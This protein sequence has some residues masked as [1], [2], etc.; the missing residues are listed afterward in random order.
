[1]FI[2]QLDEWTGGR[3]ATVQT[4]SVLNVRSGGCGGSE[5]GCAQLW[6][7][8]RGSFGEPWVT[9]REDGEDWRF[10]FL[11]IGVAK[12]PGP[13]IASGS[14]PSKNDQLAKTHAEALAPLDGA[15][16]DA[17]NRLATALL[18]ASEG[19]CTMDP[20]F[21]EQASST[22]KP[23]RRRGRIQ[24]PSGERAAGTAAARVEPLSLFFGTDEQ[25]E[26]KLTLDAVGNSATGG[27]KFVNFL[28]GGRKRRG[29]RARARVRR[30]R[31]GAFSAS[32][33][34]PHFDVCLWDYNAME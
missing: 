15:V 5:T 31:R 1:M 14:R 12:N 2:L 11:R 16:R 4:W 7:V 18:Q 30:G 21:E 26:R 27:K 28:R 22:T 13:R 6:A 29:T 17:R 20:V 10:A 33:A 34:R 19:R 3:D 32:V 9:L 8:I 25:S 24:Q 23:R